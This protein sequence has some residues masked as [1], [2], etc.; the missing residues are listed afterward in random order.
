MGVTQTERSQSYCRE[1]WRAESQYR[2]LSA[3][4]QRL[5][6]VCLAE[7]VS[8]NSTATPKLPRCESSTLIHCLVTGMSALKLATKT[9]MKPANVGDDHQHCRSRTRQRRKLSTENSVSCCVKGKAA[10]QAGELVPNDGSRILQRSV[11]SQ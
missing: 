6:A 4:I 3:Q 10:Q 11:T 7:A 9:H 8:T 5:A 1:I 2:I